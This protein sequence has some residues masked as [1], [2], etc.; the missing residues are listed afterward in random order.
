MPVK[1]CMSLGR[2]RL[3]GQHRQQWS[4]WCLKPTIP[5]AHGMG[6]W[7]LSNV[8]CLEAPLAANRPKSINPARATIQAYVILSKDG[9]CQRRLSVATACSLTPRLH[10]LHK[11]TMVVKEKAHS[12]STIWLCTRGKR[13]SEKSCKAWGV[14]NYK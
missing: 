6:E 13:Q 1:D 3:H 12:A 8:R 9:T 5:T 11:R 10:S 2:L 14:E 7:Q 4:C